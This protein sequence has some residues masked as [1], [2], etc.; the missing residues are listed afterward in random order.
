MSR[1]SEPV[2]F[3]RPLPNNTML[4]MCKQS[5]CSRASQCYRYRAVPVEHPREQDYRKPANHSAQCKFHMPL[6]ERTNIRSMDDIKR[7][8]RL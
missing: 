3:H 7:E 2:T 8:S 5:K 6:Y 1:K 4:T